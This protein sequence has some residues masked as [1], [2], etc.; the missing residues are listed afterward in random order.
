[1][2]LSKRYR[3]YVQM[4]DGF[5]DTFESWN[6][7]EDPHIPDLLIN[8]YGEDIRYTFDSV[9]DGNWKS[10]SPKD[11]PFE[12]DI[13]SNPPKAY[14]VATSESSETLPLVYIKK[15]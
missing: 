1:M 11:Y 6:E 5:F 3:Y 9:T 13:E 15:A 8:F 12:V 10:E 4:V 2:A 7:G 14:F